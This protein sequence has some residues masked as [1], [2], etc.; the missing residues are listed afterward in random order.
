[1]YGI[2]PLLAP[3]D[4]VASNANNVMVPL[5]KA[6]V[7]D[8]GTECTTLISVLDSRYAGNGGGGGHIICT[9]GRELEWFIRQIGI[10]ESEFYLNT[11]AQTQMT[12]I[13]AMSGYATI[14]PTLGL[15]IRSR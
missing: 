13:I 12:L 7:T 2:I 4:T 11:R 10:D 14:L 8:E 3:R 6:L 9:D 5:L 1:M 15:L